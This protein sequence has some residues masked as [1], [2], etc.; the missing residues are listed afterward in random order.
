MAVVCASAACSLAVDPVLGEPAPLTAP[1]IAPLTAPLTAPFVAQTPVAPVVPT[2]AAPQPV[3]VSPL[4]TSIAPR[5]TA[6]QPPLQPVDPTPVQ[7]LPAYDGS[8]PGSN[9][10]PVAAAAA[11]PLYENVCYRK[12]RNI[13]PCA[14]PMIVPIADPCHCP[15]DKCCLA[16]CVYVQICVPGSSAC[17]PR[18]ICRRN[19]HYVKYDFG[20]YEVEICSRNGKVTVDY[21]RRLLDL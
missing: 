21:H 15:K 18:V 14:V 16:N 12:E 8:L 1:L 20:R 3:L 9:P 4:D 19:G 5:V 17:P 11:I 2:E 6:A 13:A 7:P 10:V